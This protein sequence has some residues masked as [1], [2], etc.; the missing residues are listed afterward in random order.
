MLLSV[1]R[2]TVCMTVYDILFINQTIK[3]NVFLTTVNLHRKFVRNKL[4]INLKHKW[5]LVDFS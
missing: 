3:N 5:S 1:V 4:T 2:V